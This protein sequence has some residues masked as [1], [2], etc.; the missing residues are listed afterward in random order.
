MK[1]FDQL[2]EIFQHEVIRVYYHQ[3]NKKKYSLYGKIVFDRVM[4]LLLIILLSPILIGLGLWI[5]FDSKGPAIY[6]QIRVT[7]YGR[8]FEI[9]KFRTMIQDA[10]KKGSLL[11]NVVYDY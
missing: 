1:S 9:W 8:K 3:L 6:R 4:A 2:P 10:D 7:Q 5:K 11:H